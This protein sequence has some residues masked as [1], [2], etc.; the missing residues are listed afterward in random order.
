MKQSIGARGVAL[1]VAAGM[2]LAVPLAMPSSAATS[3][4]TCSKLTN[5]PPN[6]TG[7]T[8]TALKAGATG[9]FGTPPAGS[10]AGSV[11]GTFTWRNGEGKTIVLLQFAFQKT[12]RKCPTATTRITVTGK[13]TSVS[14]AAAKIIKLNEPAAGSF[15]AYVSGPKKGQT[16]LEPG[17]TF[18]M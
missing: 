15:C 12:G 17:T 9:V 14:G 16:T 1:I 3:S 18:K 11:K 7:C 10:K 13:V 5:P 2:T 4:V 6:L 8:P